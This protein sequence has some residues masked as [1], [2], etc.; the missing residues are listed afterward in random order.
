MKFTL[1]AVIAICSISSFAR[2]THTRELCV[3]QKDRVK[4]VNI[5]SEESQIRR[6]FF[7]DSLKYQLCVNQKDAEDCNTQMSEIA[8]ST[9]HECSDDKED[10]LI[11]GDILPNINRGG[12]TFNGDR[13]FLLI[14]ESGLPYEII[15]DKVIH[16]DV[17]LIQN[18]VSVAYIRSVINA[19]NRLE[20][21]AR[22]RKTDAQIKAEVISK[23]K[24]TK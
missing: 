11:M 1:I 17:V 9:A 4:Y 13:D 2:V 19:Q 14:G 16:D 8:F 21:I 20:D 24:R 5:K 15:G 22:K 6:E 3:T 18:P 23:I 12:F 7:R 10:N